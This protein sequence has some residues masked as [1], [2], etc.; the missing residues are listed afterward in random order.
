YIDNHYRTIPDRNHRAVSGLSMGGFMTFW[1]AAK[2]PDW[3]SAAGNFCG[4]TEF[5]AGLLDFPVRYAHADM[6]DNFK[7]ISMRMHNGNRDR[8]RFYHEDMNRYLMNAVPQY[9]FKQYEASHITC[10]LGDMFEFIM[11]AFES[12]LPLPE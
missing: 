1:L 8:L 9:Q 10:G 6:Y 12:P 5:L 2:F 4:S 3:V 7:G 11:K